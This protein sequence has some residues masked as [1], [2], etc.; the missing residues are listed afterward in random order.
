MIP[1]K[2]ERVAQQ[3]L[4]ACR[5]WHEANPQARLVFSPLGVGALAMDLG[6][7]IKT[8]GV[9]GNSIT[10]QLLRAMLKATDGGATVLMAEYAIER[11]Y[12]IPEALSRPRN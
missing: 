11:V 3:C 5:Q 12:G 1:A 8:Y 10:R 4:E 7:A 6:V 2:Y 9:A